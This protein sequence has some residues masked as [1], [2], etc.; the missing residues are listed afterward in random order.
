MQMKIMICPISI[1]KIDE[2]YGISALLEL[3][4]MQVC[5]NITYIVLH[6]MKIME[7]VQLVKI[8]KGSVSSQ[9]D[10]TSL[11]LRWFISKHKKK[12]ESKVKKLQ[13]YNEVYIERGGLILMKFKQGVGESIEYCRLICICSK[14][15]NKWFVRIDIGNFLWNKYFNNYKVFESL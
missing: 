13:T 9:G 4:G 7:L 5:S 10:Y 1:L 6:A 15:Y 3:K 11:N 8:E 12:N 2:R 14:Y